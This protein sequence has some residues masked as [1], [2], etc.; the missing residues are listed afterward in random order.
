MNFQGVTIRVHSNKIA[1]FLAL[2]RCVPRK[3]ISV[4][5]IIDG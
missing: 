5:V 4:V 2:A 3:S 1:Q